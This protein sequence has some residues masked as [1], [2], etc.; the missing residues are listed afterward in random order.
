MCKRKGWVQGAVV[1]QF[2]KRNGTLSRPVIPGRFLSGIQAG[3]TTARTLKM[4]GHDKM[5]HCLRFFVSV[6]TVFAGPEENVDG[7]PA[8]HGTGEI[9]LDIHLARHYTATGF[10][11]KP[12]VVRR[13]LLNVDITDL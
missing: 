7:V 8:L 3:P 10:P 11:Q 4:F 9:P 12:E 1:P 13:R 2:G 5:R 6:P